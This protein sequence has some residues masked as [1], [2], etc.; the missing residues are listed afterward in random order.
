MLQAWAR[1]WQR[2]P[3]PDE[4]ERVI[5]EHIREEIYYR[6]ALALGLERDDTI[7]RRRLR[8][9]MEFLAED[10]QQAGDP[11]DAELEAYLEANAD[12]FHEPALLTFRHIYFSPDRRGDAAPGDAQRVRADLTSETEPAEIEKLGDPFFLEREFDASSENDIAR[13]FGR[14]FVPKLLAL[15]PGEWSGP[16][17]SG[18][19]YHL[20]LVTERVDG[21]APALDEIRDSVL[22]EWRSEER[23]RA[24]E[25]FYQSLRARYTVTVEMPAT[26]EGDEQAGAIPR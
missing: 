25:E 12:R 1:T 20:V 7:I 5:E 17:Q 16:L 21:R 9:K 6:E 3:T 13:V 26:L 24:A 11:G 2:P 18:F 23:E 19:G 22:S 4:V 8:Q 10:F 14:E 15:T